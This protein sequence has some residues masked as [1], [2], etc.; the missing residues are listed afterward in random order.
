MEFINYL[1]ASIASYL[2]AVLG[3]LL[4]HL[5][6]EEQSPGRKFFIFLKN[7]I[8]L[9]I[10]FFLLFYEFHW[11]ILIIAVFL[12]G[13]KIYVILSENTQ[14]LINSLPDNFFLGSAFYLSSEKQFL[15][16][17]ISSLIFLF[18]MANSSLIYDLK[19]KNYFM[20]MSINFIFVLTALVFF[21]FKIFS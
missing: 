13:I 1:L 15:F 21:N 14:G 6:P 2:G 11:Q 10:L 7:L 17:L 3:I 9:L 19:R 18:C 4:I 12:L 5:A 8:L 20:V 16:I